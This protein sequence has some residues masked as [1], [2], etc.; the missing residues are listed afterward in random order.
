MLQIPEFAGRLLSQWRRDELE[1]FAAQR[2]YDPPKVRELIDWM[3]DNNV[4]SM[5]DLSH[6]EV[7][8]AAKQLKMV[9]Y[10]SLLDLSGRSTTTDGDDDPSGSTRAE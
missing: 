9:T 6:D 5:Q 3:I 4:D 2:R 10:G 7:I 1:E 8:A